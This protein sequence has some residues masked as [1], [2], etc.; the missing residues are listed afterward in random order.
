MKRVSS[1]KLRRTSS[2]QP[3]ARHRRPRPLGISLARF[4][5]AVAIA[6]ALFAGIGSAD[7][8]TG[9]WILDG[10]GNW[11][12]PATNWD[13]SIVANGVGDIAIFRTNLA[14]NRI[15]TLDAPITLG[16][17][18]LGDA[19]GAQTFTFAG[20]GA[21]TLTFD[22]GSAAAASFNKYNSTTDVWQAP[23]VLTSNLNANIHSGVLDVNG[24]GNTQVSFT[25]AG[26]TIKNG[27][28][29]LQLNIDA[30][31]GAGY[32]GNFTV[33]L[34][35]LRIGG[36]NSAAPTSL[37]MG[38]NGITLNGSG[39]ADLA[40]LD[41]RN[42]GT[43]V[44]N[45][46]IVYAGNNNVTLQGGA[47]INVD[48]N[49]ISAGTSTGNTV[50]LGNLTAN[51]GILSVTSGNSYR[52]KFAGT[53]DLVGD[54]NVFSVA[55]NGTSNFASLTLSG[56]ISDGLGGGRA[57]I[58]EGA[59]RMLV[60]AANTYTGP[61]AIK[62]GVLQL[63]ASASLASAVYVNGGALALANAGQADTGT[64][65][66]GLNLVSQI[67]TSRASLAAIVNTGFDID[68]GNALNVT[69]PIYGMALEVDTIANN[70][71]LSQVGGAGNTRV[72][73]SNRLGFDSTYTGSL[74]AASN[75]TLRLASASNN[76][77]LSTA[78]Q[79]GGASSTAPL[80]IGVDAATPTL[81][82]GGP[83]IVRGTGGTVSVRANNSATLGPVTVNRGVTLN[84]NGT[85]LTTP[86]G[87]GIVTVFGGTVSTDAATD[88]K[89]GNTDFR[90][91]GGGTLL[92][93]NSGVAAGNVDRRLLNTTDID[94]TSSTLRLIGDGGA[95][96]ASSQS[97]NSVDYA[98]GST[99]SVDT[100][101]T[102]AARLTT[103]TAASLNR[104][105]RG[106][107]NIRSIS[108]N[109]TTFGTAAGTQK[110]IITA[111][112]TVT[113]GMIGANIA[114]WGGTTS[115]DGT[116]PLFATYD[117][118][119]G[120]QA[121]AFNLSGAAV[122]T[123]AEFAAATAGQIVSI[124]ALTANMTVTTGTVQALRIRSTNNTTQSVNTGT[125]TIGSLAAVGQG[126]GLQLI[127]T[128]DNTVT[129]SA[130]F[131]FG[132]Q[133][134]AIYA[135]TTG[136]SSI[137]DLT[138]VIT[139]SNGLTR[140][141]DG[142]LRLS[143]VNPI[144][145][146]VTINSGETRVNNVSALGLVTG[147]TNNIELLGGALY[148]NN[149]NTRYNN[150]V[151][152]NNDA[153]FGNVNI[154]GTGIN[155][156]TVNARTGS[157]APIVLD[158]RNQ[159]GN[160][161]TTVYGTTTLNGPAQV[162]T[163][164]I[165]HTNGPISGTGSLE[166][167]GNERWYLAG[168]SSGYAQ[169]VTVNTGVLASL[170]A[171]TAAKPFGTGALTIN[172]GGAIRVA[173][174]T[175]VNAGQVTLNSDLG[176]ISGI[177][178]TYVGDPAAITL[179][180]GSSAPGWRGYVGLPQVGFNQNID[181]STLW[182][183]NTY[184]GAT[185]GE[186][187][188]FAGT[189]TPAAGN[190]FLLGT[191]QGTLR[192]AS[193]LTGPNSAVIGV[194][195]TGNVGRANQTV[196]NSGGSV[197]YAV[198]MS[199]AGST[200]VHQNTNLII[201]ATSATTALG[202][203]T[204][205]GGTLR[206]DANIGQLR[207]NA[208]LTVPNAINL[209]GDSVVSFSNN[210][211]ALRLGG[212]LNLA[213]GSTGVVRQLFVTSDN[214]GAEVFNAGILYFDGGISD[215]PGGSGNHFI[216][217]GPGLAMLTG[218]QTYTGTTTV[219][220]GFLG[221]NSDADL[222]SSSQI[223]LASGGLA[224]LENSFTT[225]RNISFHGGNGTLDV[226][227]GL[228]LTQSSASTYDGTSF[229]IK[230][231][232]GT[233]VL[234]GNNAMT[235]LLAA[236]GVLQVNSQ[237]A[238][239][240]GATTTAIQ[241]GGD[242]NVG[243][244]NNNTRYTGGTL[245]INGTFTTNRGLTFN[246]NGNTTFGGGIDVT[247]GNT[248]TVTGV[249]TQGTENDFAFKTG[250]GTL[251]TT[252]ANGGRQYAFTNGTFQFGNST[253]WSNSTTTAADNTNIEFL[254]GTVRAV[255]TSANIALTNNA[256]TT[257]Y[258][259]GGG[260]HLRLESGT[261]FS[262]EFAGDNL[263][264]AN[265]G[266]LVIETAGGTT[267]GGVGASNAARLLTTNA[268]NSGLARGS[269]LTNGIFAP[270]LITADAAGVATFTTNDAATGIKAFSFV[271]AN[272]VNAAI[273]STVDSFSSAQALTAD[274]S[275]YAFSTTANVSGGTLRIQAIDNLRVG[276]ILING[277]NTISSNLIFDPATIT[278]IGAGTLGEGLVYVKTGEN[279]AITGAVTSNAFTKF[280][281]GTLTLGNA[282]ILSELS[283]QD[284]TLKIGAG[285]LTSR[286]NTEL[287]INAGAT[288]DL[289]GNS[290]T[291]ETLGA[292][293]RSVG[294]TGIAS[295]G[296]SVTN[297][298]ALSTLEVG[299]PVTG[300]YTGTING[301]L[302]LQK[303]GVG[304][305]NI[306]GY[307]ASTPDAGNNTFTGGTEIHGFNT[308][309]GINLDN[310]TFGLGGFGTAVQ[311][312][313][314][315]YSGTLGLLFSNGNTGINGT[316]GQQFNNQVVKFGSETGD[317]LTLNVRGPGQINVNQGTVSTNTAFGQGNIMQVGTLN[318]SN[319]TLSLSGGNLYRVR[320]AGTTTIQGSQAAF[321]TNSDG[322]S[323]ALEL[324]GLVTGT[325]A[326]TKLGDGTLRGI[327][328]SNP[329]NTYS[330][331][332]NIV[333]GDVQVT[334]TS[335]SALGSGAIRVFPDGTLR[336]A[337]NGSI[338]GTK[339]EVYSR[340]NALGAVSLDEN[341]NPTVLTSTNFT[342]AYNSTLQLSQ[343]FFTQPLNLTAIGDGRAF[344]GS[345]LNTEVRYMAPT[346]GAGVADAWS[347][348]GVYRLVGGVN[349]LGF[350]AVNNVLTGPNY[351]QVGP[352]R[353]N[354]LGVI[355]NSGGTVVFRNSNNYSAG[356]QIT[357]GTA[358][359]VETG[360]SPIG[361]T[362]LGTG[363]VEVYGTLNYA[364]SLG[365]NWK[366]DSST[367]TN[368]VNLRPG[369]FINLVDGNSIGIGGNHVAGGQG[370]W[371]DAIGI[372][373]NGG[374]IRL[375]GAAAANTVET[376][377]PV[378]VRKGGVLSVLRG[379]GA[380]SAQFNVGALTRHA[381][382]TLSITHNANFLGNNVT[383]PLSFERLTVAGG[384][385]RTG[386]TT[387]GAGSV[388]G[389]IAPVWIVD[390]TE[391]TYVGYDPTGSGSGFQPLL[392]A[393]P[394]AGQLAYN[395]IL[396]GA[397]IG[398]LGAL[399]T[400][401]VTTA[402]KTLAANTSLHALRF[403][404]SISPTG[405]FNTLTINSG[406]FI[407]T[408]TP[409]INPI[410]S[411][412]AGVVSP[413]TINFGAGGAGEAIIYNAGNMNTYA[414][415]NA[416]LGLTKFGGSS[417]E[418]RSINPGIGGPVTVNA[419]NLI[420]RV[421]F[422]GT[423]V[424]VGQVFNSQD[425]ILN[426]GGLLLDPFISNAAGIATEIA[427][428]VRATALFDSDIFVR[429]NASLTNN[430]Q[431]QYVRIQD[432][433]IENGGGATAMDGNGI[434][435]LALSSGIWAR[436]TTT[437]IP[438]ATFNM[439]FSGFA[440]STF[441]GQVTQNGVSDLEKF[442]NGTMT[443]LNGTNNY[444]GGTTI[445]G[446]TIAQ[447]VSTV[448]S[449]FRGTG[450][451]FGTGDIK[452]QPGGLLRVADNAN[453]AS[454]AVYLR[455]DGYALG[456]L[457]LAHNGALPT[458]VTAG[459]PAAGEVKVEST[460]PFAGVITLD[461]GYYSQP[462]NMGTVP[463]GAWYLGNSQQNDAYYFNSTLGA[464]TGGKYLLGGGGNQGSLQLGS[465]LV[466][467][468]RTSLFENIL[469][470]GTA[471]QVKVEI[472]AQ[473]G[474]FAWNSP[475]FVNGNLG[476][477][478]LTTRN[479]GLVGDV[480]VNT[481]TTLGVG[482]NFALGSGR[483]IVNGGT[484]RF[485]I[486]NNN[487]IATDIT[488]NNNVVLQ[489]DLNVNAGNGVFRGDV[490]MSDVVGA[491]ATRI[492]NI[493]GGALA[494]R[495]VVSGAEG[496]NLIK[497]GGS[498]LVLTGANTYQGYTQINAGA[499]SIAGDVIPNQ[500]GPLGNSSSPVILAGGV[501]RAAGKLNF[502]RDVHVNA[503]STLD[504]VVAERVVVNGGISIGT[505]FTLTAGAVA[506]GVDTFRGGTLQFNGP[507]SG[508]G[509]LAVGTT[510]AAPA[511]GGT[512][513]FSAL[514]NG[515]GTNTY[516]GGT[517]FQSAR[518]QLSGNTYFT[519][520]A[521]NPTTI[522]SGPLGT[523]AIT[524]GNATQFGEANRGAIF[525]AVGG[526]VTI[527][528]VL[529]PMAS[530]ANTTISF[531]GHEALE[532][533]RPLNVNSDATLRNRT[534][535]VQN[536]HQPV[537][538][539]GALSAS[540]AAG[541]NL[542]KTGPGL[543]ILN[544]ANTFA[545]SATTGIQ[546][547]QG[548]LRINSDAALGAAGTVRLNG[549]VLSVSEDI[550][551]ARPL[552]LQA[553]SGLDV[554]PGK[555]LTLTAATTGGFAVTK[556]GNG[557]LALNASNTITTLTIGGQAQ[558][559]P[560]AA[561]YNNTGGIVSTT[562]TAG[563]PFATSTVTING[564]AL[565]LIGGGVAQAL[566]VPTINYGAAAAI[567][568]FQGA[569]TSQLTAGTA[570]NRAGLFNT[571]NYGTLTVVPSALANLGATEKL[572]ITAGAPANT[573]TGG[574]NI[575][576]VP[577]I[578]ARLQTLG[579]A[580]F[581]RYDAVG[582]IM[583]H[584]VATVGTLAASA[585]ANV[586]DIAAADVA[587]AG[588]IDVQALRTTA[589]I[590]PTDGTTLVRLARGG[591]IINGGT[592]STLSAPVLF[593]TGAGASLTEGIVYVREGQTGTSAITGGITARDL[594][595][596][597]PG[598]LEI[599]GSAGTN[600]LNSNA[601]RLPVVSV[602]DGTLRFAST[603][604]QFQN[605]LRGTT[606]GDYLGHYA[607]NVNEAGV[608]DLNGLTLTAGALA[609]NGTITSNVAGAA[610]LIVKNGF[611]VDTTFNGGIT[612]GAGTVG[613]T[614]SQNGVLTLSGYSTY[615]GGTTIQAGRVTNASGLASALGRVEAQT[616]EALGSGD[617][618][619][620][621]GT[622]RLNAAA[623]LNGAQNL[624]ESSNNL[625]FL[626]WG[627]GSG[628]NIVVSSSG[629]SNGVALPANQTSTLNAATRTAGINN[630]TI[631][632]PRLTF[633]EGTYHVNGT[634]TLSQANTVLRLAGGTVYLAGKLDAAGKTITKVG[635]NTLVLSNT[636][637]GA[638]QNDVGLWKVYGGLV[639]L[640][641]ADG[642][643]NP[644]GSSA[645]VE[646]NT[647]SAANG[648]QL[649]TDGDGT[650]LTER[651]TTY[652]NTNIRFGS[653][654]PVSDDN[655]VSAGQSR[656]AVDRAQ[657]ANS[658]FKTVEVNNLEV[659]GTLGSAF[660]YFV[661][662]NNDS[663]RVNGT[664]TFQRDLRLQ[665]DGGQGI[666]LNGL[667]SGN[668][669]FSR[670]SN[671]GS[672][673]INADNSSG[674][675][676]G[677]FFTGSGRNYL[678]SIDGSQVTLSNTAK[679]GAGHVFLGP[680]ALFQIN[681]AGNLQ[682]DQ[683]I[684]VTGN[685]AFMANFSL[686]A[687]LSLDTVRLRSLG[688]GGI[689]NSP[690]DYYLSASNPSSSVLS[691][692]TIYTQPLN[693]AA[694]GDGMWYLGSA[695]NGMG[696]NGAY[697][698]AT[699]GAGLGN[700]YRLGAG[701]STLFLGTNGNAN[702][703]TGSASLVVGTPM[704]VQNFAP[705]SNGTGSVVLMQNQ[706]YT[707]STLVNLNSTLDF[708]GTLQTSGF[709]VRGV[710]N[711]AGEAGTFLAGGAGPNIP[712]T[713]R[714]GS[715][716]R[717]DNTSAGVLPTSATQ[718]RWED[719]VAITLNDSI[720]RLQGNSAVEVVETVGAITANNGANRI[721][722]VRGVAGRGTELR[723]PSITRGDFG[724]V[725]LNTN[726]GQLGADERVIITG[727]AP[728]VTNGMVLPWMI[729]NNDNQFVTYN[730]DTGFTIA[731]FDRV[732]VGGTLTSATGAL[733]DRL[734]VNSGTAT[735][736]NGADLSAYAMRFEG[737]DL[738][739]TAAGADTSA[740]N[741][742]ILG[743]G[744]LIVNGA[745]TIQSGLWGGATGTGELV[746]Y[747]N[748][749]LNVGILANNTTSGRIKAD[750]GI[751]KFGGGTF[752]ILSEQPGFT[753]DIRVQ[754]GALQFQW[755]GTSAL[756]V[757]SVM[758]GVGGDI[759][760]QGNN[761]QL[762]LRI[763]NDT[764][765]AP[766][767]TF[768]FN[769]NVVIGDDVSVAQI[770]YDRAGGGITGKRMIFN[771]LE[772]GQNTGDNGQVLRLLGPTND[773]YSIQFNGTTTLKGRSAFSVENN[774]SAGANDAFLMGKVTGTGMLIKGPSDSKTRTLFIQNV[775]GLN[776]WSGGTVLQGGTLQALARATNVAQNAST[777]IV[778]GGLG[779]ASSVTVLGGTLDLRVDGA[780]TGAADTDIEFLRYTSGAGVGLDLNVNGS[781]AIFADRN[782]Y[783]GTYAKSGTTVTATLPG[784][785]GFVNGQTVTVTT[786]FTAA[787]FVI[788]S[789]VDANT[790]TYTDP[791][792][793][794]AVQ[795]FFA[796]NNGSSSNKML[797]FNNMTIGGQILTF[798]SGNGYGMAVAGTTNLQGN[799][800][801]NV[802]ADLVIGGGS[803]AAGTANSITSGGGQV[804]INKVGTSTLW[805]HSTNNALTGPT[806]INAG[807]LD[808]GNRAVAN[809]TAT[810]GIGDIYIN[811]GAEI[812]VRGVGNINTGSGQQVVLTSTPYSTSTFLAAVST[813]TQAQYQSMIATSTPTSNEN[814]VI[815]FGSGT[816]VAQNLDQSTIGNG[817][818][819]FGANTAV[820]YNGVGTGSITPGLAN[821]AESVSGGAST[822][823]VYRLGGRSTNTLTIDLAGAGNL[824]DVG[825]PT[826]VQIGSQANLGPSAN[827]GLG[828][829]LFG[830]QNSYTGQTIVSRGSILRFNQ[831]S[832]AG[833]ASGPLGAN[834][835]N[836]IDVYGTLQAEGASGAGG[837]FVD[838]GGTDNAYTNLKLHPGS[839][840]VF[841][842]NTASSNRW[843]VDAGIALDGARLTLD[844][845]NNIDLSAEDV[846]PITFDRGARIQTVNQGTSEILLTAD[847]ITRAAASAGAGTGRGTMVFTPGTS[848]NL[849]LPSATNNAEQV[850]F[851]T[852]PSASAISTVAGIL[853]GY[854]VDGTGNRFVTHNATTGI[855]PV[856]DGAMTGT[857]PQGAGT[858][859]VVVNITAAATMGS[860]SSTIYGLRVGAFTISSPTGANNDATINF[861]GSG[862][863]VGG[864]ISTGAATINPNLNFGAEEALFYAGGG[865]I[866]V[867]GNLTAGSVTKFGTN[868]LI[869]ANDQSNNARGSGQGYQGGWVV[870]EGSLNL[871]T[872]GSAG[873][874][875][876][877][878]T[879]VLNGNIL[880]SPT[881]FL[882]AITT[883]DL[884]N[885]TYSSGRVIA[886]DNA[887]IDWDPAVADR[888]HKMADIEI[889]QSGGI[890]NAT[891]NGTND[892]LLRVA[893]ANN[894][895]ILAAGQLFVTNNAIL[896]VDAT[897][898][899]SPFVA[900]GGNAAYLNNGLS[901]GLSVASLSGSERLTKWG[902]GYL[903]IR[904]ASPGFS[905]PLVIDQGAVYVTNNGSLGSG[906]VTVNR[907][908]IL[909]IG[910]ASFNP[911]T[912]TSLTYNEGSIERWS[913]NN[914]R[915]GAVNLG[916]ATLQVAADQ[917]T[918][919][920]TITLNGGSI[921]A[922]L[923]NDDQ[924]AASSGA[925]VM[926]VLNPNVDFV[927]AGDSF[928]GSQYYL[929]ANGLDN[930][931]QTSDNRPLEEYLASGAILDIKG[932]IS[933]TGG[934]TKVGYDT[935]ILS[936]TNIYAGATKVEGGK[937][938]I[939]KDNALPT[940]TTLTT[941]ANSVLDLN[942][943][944]QTVGRLTNPVAVSG[945]NVT[946]GF[947]TNSSTSVKTLTVGNGSLGDAVYSGIIQHNVGL[948]KIGTSIQQ[949]NND[950]TYTGPTTVQSGTLNISG[951]INATSNVKLD[952]GTLLLTGTSNAQVN[953]LAPVN[954]NGGTLAFDNPANQTENL[955]TLTLSANSIIDFGLGGGADQFRFASLPVHTAGTLSI[956]NWIGQSAG[957]AFV[958]IDGTDD[959]LLFSGS[960][961][962]FI[963]A[964][965]Q[966]DVSFNGFSGYQAI[967]FGGGYEIVPV[968][969]PSSTALL[970]AAGLLA[971]VGYRER[972][973]LR[974]AMQSKTRK[975]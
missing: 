615:S 853:P 316:L 754:Q 862:T 460:G 728:T 894:R 636:A 367:A 916:K 578:F 404:Q 515:Y 438:Q 31:S 371:G 968:P 727:A 120:V 454:N 122:D 85:G 110:L 221:I 88:A 218:T 345:G 963:S 897:S 653:S 90:L 670:N 378:D 282:S 444:T 256:S 111:A 734:L 100:D 753:G 703:L 419:G 821:L 27:A 505:G 94:L 36:A 877:G 114:L 337:G 898:A 686:A 637:V 232:L 105:G 917:P 206:S 638:G 641:T 751:T 398:A 435:N 269:A 667:I 273:A 457:G 274:R 162:Y 393:A 302:K 265:Q 675:S 920:A 45:T 889:Q 822:N 572:M 125:I 585:S 890:G 635:A 449:G 945:P 195:M 293:N 92:L 399:D 192:V 75:G 539:S 517:T 772:F 766:G 7:A 329:G 905:G 900:Y 322:P 49:Y 716:L 595:K 933:G 632:A 551:T 34:G 829:V 730:A 348:N 70:I 610:N 84:I 835:A 447:Q 510:A 914:A 283:V 284:G 359:Q 96:T 586:A 422:S 246:N 955:G 966:A 752:Q 499:L 190:R 154:G 542:I 687:D 429:G 4:T 592:A 33:N 427:S 320:V 871:S 825:G 777:N 557:T 574:G 387:N 826:D 603:G 924:I 210:A 56:I 961:S 787:N 299:S 80:I 654:L 288:L 684:Y 828:Q 472:G 328:L 183:G 380:S 99:I 408:G 732:Q 52:L 112:P 700:T 863:D 406:G 715:T 833:G 909:D 837:T 188:I 237:A 46:D 61:T 159:A 255:N 852:G 9:T 226:A 63:G 805:V 767:G 582:G 238:L 739:L 2:T 264:R 475:A 533:T 926:R 626:Q 184:I 161:V 205:N 74:T 556:T 91:Y 201:S 834:G 365:S 461:Y 497:N 857:L 477:V 17:I 744:G 292:N 634:T 581:T 42:N 624:S 134:A 600:A 231:G 385:T 180:G 431:A 102:T 576:T 970:G 150:N 247:A 303:S 165:F 389:G 502:D 656:V 724:T 895:N 132:T 220:A 214:I 133:E 589:N 522:L 400:V 973:R 453:I 666:T 757:A 30:V 98:G 72:Y 866:T 24:S 530:A 344:L 567:A 940:T 277:S 268:I 208:P 679:L 58:K 786:G 658:S 868:Q 343:A 906:A 270:H 971:L 888:V 225:N 403:N 271:P 563:T 434:I 521:S 53:T 534:F 278:A 613:L 883:D 307:R 892:A 618:T 755:T 445:W 921:E 511:I 580:N 648:L 77:I 423:G 620:Q 296:G 417:I 244:A 708:R 690:T 450:T 697:D 181:Q 919:S 65:P 388:N 121:A 116:S 957:S 899:G 743:S 41:L 800:L 368:A 738:N 212:P 350:D 878:N 257:N 485:D 791:A 197:V 843:D 295:V 601:T 160:N 394:G 886:V 590:T 334:A 907:Y 850:K 312:E 373:L 397:T 943:Q 625:E 947:I 781:T 869:I 480:R 421:P 628:L 179:A 784:G 20:S 118:T 276:G 587:G 642:A 166:K 486:G 912:N 785:H 37:G 859:G 298:G 59:G 321:Q 71:D 443:L 493:S 902:D 514:S 927:L 808:F 272:D 332:T 555:T 698:A 520:P 692:G 459:T 333:A 935:V 436:G 148:L 622:L 736:L 814:M 76:L 395:Q 145:G 379:T 639:Q 701:G 831:P 300:T 327:V 35:T 409:T 410:G 3:V 758:G 335:G 707:G 313:V 788:T 10:A 446:T 81:F 795:G 644:L 330:G 318:M 153:R 377:G 325:G 5:S 128:A 773:A 222:A 342:S 40:V 467:A 202:D 223:I 845:A 599:G 54:T 146:T 507:I 207:M 839:T 548:T 529:Q 381:G 305:L 568:L 50:V 266:T 29:T 155:N 891:A 281:S 884:Q 571:V 812:N 694:L 503:S 673:Y 495:G 254:G 164:H 129:H 763:G 974:N 922:W 64:L 535:A 349:N 683:N 541:V 840:L 949:L 297:T 14:A 219:A 354:V 501:L 876:P 543:L 750:G 685:L 194:S 558:L 60:E 809:A 604:A 6:G 508:P 682:A 119:H 494:V 178:L 171:D 550:S 783:Q 820:T 627:R 948:T 710:L 67:G 356:T 780:A 771:N 285:G 22:T 38:L 560:N 602:Q 364:S 880:G 217:A 204:L 643:S 631:D 680:L 420:A 649:L 830:D 488:L 416:A 414:Q 136:A 793:G 958:G 733:T 376:I 66:N 509:A 275:I 904:G 442:G 729:S 717:F 123:A 55:A 584:N 569:T 816:A 248:F 959:R 338:D 352:Q 224:V 893:V 213:P 360:G 712:V 317:G 946:S 554:A 918:T 280:G 720:L 547:S 430:G 441:E 340:V 198:P 107:L 187:G 319:A 415:M 426:G 139:G 815:A 872:F 314:N 807:R 151:I 95:A 185:V 291:V 211:S 189:L 182:G 929:G 26:N 677:T 731:G 819:F 484:V 308:T 458:I 934:L 609:G 172:P 524:F 489:G 605:Q 23:L 761:T 885:Y 887:T 504:T 806:Y 832:A 721:D 191:G 561:Y 203:I 487:F 962:D 8:A 240:D 939:G 633:T 668:G 12:T 818:V 801:L 860:F 21:N 662:A 374:T 896:N 693:L 553:N 566:S 913:V 741:R 19:L 864:V 621:G 131:S 413:M 135:S 173:A 768:S 451:P 86:V 760:L 689:Q 481:S 611:G 775:N 143:G 138:G 113:N 676:G 802:G 324:A 130:N 861:S 215:G 841:L 127:H 39:R 28:G 705:L 498:G 623:L 147:A 93:D 82:A 158:L 48:R 523:G 519:G 799:A 229:L 699:L 616:V 47:T 672:L 545:T 43:N 466:S 496:S 776:D 482:N 960:S 474:D 544:G 101:G 695:T 386:N 735:V 259:Y 748:N 874:T 310:A 696:A 490:A 774:Y 575:L 115:N 169:P 713:L 838:A 646:L 262:V 756:S 549:G 956:T 969:E 849:G 950:N 652:A 51:G 304:V 749:T 518:V 241:F 251:I 811:P 18:S 588:N 476:Y 532:F 351:L 565:A 903:Y 759:V 176:G 464:A 951:S 879:I 593:G 73:L 341:F 930:G 479:T 882:R 506:G 306:D 290:I 619:L 674:Y 175:N 525:E 478:A 471:N 665:I 782:S 659:N 141:G 765:T 598:V 817:R 953:D 260:G 747:N 778:A 167:F 591:L 881:L 941:T 669:T 301:T 722:V 200:T 942:G 938:M 647:G 168:D 827:W 152:F 813:F 526:P 109:T 69:V 681:D 331:G 614:K 645:T 972:R 87:A 361:E 216:K 846:G 156:L 346:L 117:A 842:D 372:D 13:S 124:D 108:G 384:V 612:N 144:T 439:T 848:A 875:D 790:F 803:G 792:A 358:I 199:Y 559:N 925:G 382:S 660:A 671:G 725:Q 932:E 500:A 405:T 137:V 78:N 597:G 245:R 663:L 657:V 370:R 149:T 952:G 311:P 928:L 975:S 233:L 704:T 366:A 931:R 596:T 965:S 762:I 911:T 789:I 250:L 242:F 540:G 456:G 655:F 764:W 315:L 936:G 286:M 83:A 836:L 711:V 407:N 336:L 745:R 577:S 608:L 157:A 230:R 865:N 858:P 227:G 855:V 769:N 106:T 851:L 726:G 196:N 402:A 513:L 170:N 392:G 433:T 583:E 15:V 629:I 68:S 923:R 706:N 661:L 856:G 369:G 562:A 452:I 267:L 651:V 870:N 228:T 193:P 908:G 737:A 236:D 252:G 579:D 664:T 465:V 531:G 538:F 823:R 209:T 740:T 428:S 709:D 455:S 719:S 527:V 44:S 142:V 468:G 412:T 491:G 473:T 287:N 564:G 424:A 723:T 186:T 25:G 678:G 239:G 104:T 235:G 804:L 425:I 630:L 437:L 964:F 944:D 289:N 418:V 396:T 937:L 363:A 440:Q 355:T 411:I 57:L 469:S 516:A 294:T 824:N 779:S 794:A 126:A 339:L 714:P 62:D 375:T 536:M 512:V 798:T 1:R 967:S 915:S 462:L 279:A 867:N 901:S 357:A 770:N 16:S 746:I 323:G 954:L 253:P 691:L 261:G 362:P 97:V 383:T 79:L 844:A 492:W 249:M 546:I 174:P 432:L 470:G 11:T 463:G 607:L 797:T 873:N 528:N 140:F 640:R 258:N 573:A 234:N 32:T 103:L 552:T 796:A 847:S 390:A 910:V 326:I 650:G 309:G 742:I 688:L 606:V 353:N 401:D 391:N 594:T 177:V 448:A 810:L 163:S 617:V 89:F 483:L 537:T 347:A 854:F 702:V 243:N 718:G 570:F 263:V